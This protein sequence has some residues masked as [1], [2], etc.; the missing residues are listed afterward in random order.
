MYRELTGRVTTSVL[1][2]GSPI[3]CVV[4][5][6]GTERDRERA[7]GH[8][9]MDAVAGARGTLGR[10]ETGD[11][12]PKPPATIFLSIVLGLPFVLP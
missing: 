6:Q 2:D 10:H 8:F 11:V 3:P 7:V 4:R 12:P 1:R 9:V 5:D